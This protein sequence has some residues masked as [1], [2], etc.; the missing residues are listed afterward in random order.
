MPFIWSNKSQ[1]F[2]GRIRGDD[3]MGTNH[4]E[5]IDINQYCSIGR[6][7]S[8]NGTNSQDN[9]N[10]PNSLIS[11]RS[12]K[13]CG[14]L[15][16]SALSGESMA[17]ANISNPNDFCAEIQK[18]DRAATE[19]YRTLIDSDYS[20]EGLE[21]ALAIIHDTFDALPAARISYAIIEGLLLRFQSVHRQG[22]DS[23]ANQTKDTM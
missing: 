11:P 9:Q 18:L 3:D 6:K 22:D 15:P 19:A 13:T 16:Q 10:N 14:A 7:G 1:S 23:D 8:L 5:V 2:V 4:G 17:A 21:A 20:G 12:E